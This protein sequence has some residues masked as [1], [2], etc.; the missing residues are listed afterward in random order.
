MHP[1]I[2]AA[3]MGTPVVGLAYNPKFGGFLQLI[4]RADACVEVEDFV[5]EG[6]PTVLAG[7]LGDALRAGRGPP[8]GA[9]SLAAQVLAFDAALL[10]E[11]T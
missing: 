3:A 6:D 11:I 5:R 9:M 8:D 4:S 7:L 10:A 2:L 1:M